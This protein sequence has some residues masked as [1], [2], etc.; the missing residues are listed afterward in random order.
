MGPTNA[1][2]SH[3]NL[4]HNIALIRDAIGNRKIMAVVKANAYGHGDVEV[5]RTALAT[6]CEYLGVAFVEEGEILR[7]AGITAP[8]L[9]FGPHHPEFILRAIESNLEITITCHDQIE[10]LKEINPKR[11]VR[12]HL[13]I[14]TGMNRVGF[15]HTDFRS[16]LDTIL[17]IPHIQLSGVYS[18]FS[19]S[20]EEDNSFAILQ[21]S[22]FKK[23]EKYI[24]NIAGDEVIFHMANSGAIMNH[25]DS[26]FDM[27]RPGIMLYGQPPGP[28]FKLKWNLQEVMSLQSQLGLIKLT[29][30]NEPVSYG[31][32][33]YTKDTTHIGVIPIGYADGFSRQNTNNGEVFINHRAYPIVGTVCMDM[34]MVDLGKNS[35]CEQGDIVTLYGDEIPIAKIAARLNT[36]PYEITC[37]VSRRVPRIHIYD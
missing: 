10:F 9:V 37:N 32:R 2:I 31:R 19:T 11:T 6:G 26:Y 8:I 5:A 21:I 35:D 22:R 29:K 30:K 15:S 3:P 34:I 23:V 1:Y 16:V 27:V 28:E 7:K 33:Y 18:H 4:H 25:P 13:K 12:I 24:R 20:D 36:I 17:Q 14:D